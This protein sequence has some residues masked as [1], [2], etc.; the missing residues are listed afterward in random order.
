MNSQ[1][2]ERSVQVLLY[3]ITAEKYDDDLVGHDM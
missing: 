2:S 3:Q 1:K